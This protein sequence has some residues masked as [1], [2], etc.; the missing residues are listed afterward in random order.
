M[1]EYGDNP[2]PEEEKI[3][4]EQAERIYFQKIADQMIKEKP[5]EKAVKKRTLSTIAYQEFYKEVNKTRLNSNFSEDWEEKAK[6]LIK[7][8][9]EKISKEIMTFIHNE[10]HTKIGALFDKLVSYSQ[11]RTC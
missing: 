4:R 8:F 2:D 1:G 10:D 5:L 11:K 6:L 7:Y 9:P 3:I